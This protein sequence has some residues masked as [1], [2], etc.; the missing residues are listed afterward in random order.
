[1]SF[2]RLRLI[3]TFL[4]FLT[5]ALIGFILKDRLFPHKAQE[6]QPRYQP[7]YAAAGSAGHEEVLAEPVDAEPEPETPSARPAEPKPAA[8]ERR[9]PEA[10]VIETS[11]L[12]EE[13]PPQAPEEAAVPEKQKP[14]PPPERG[15][16]KGAQDDFFASPEDYAGKD[17][18]VELQMIT[19]RRT[20][21]GWRLN[22]V[23]SGPDKKIDYLYADD[24]DVLGEKPDLRI[25][26]VYRVRFH[27][28]KGET[29]SGNTLLLLT[30]TG[31][32]AVWA[33][34]L[35]AIE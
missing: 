28:A 5:G 18:E 17:L 7:E 4:F 16:V 13:T 23:Y 35:S 27:C 1:M 12:P 31:D 15:I 6:T 29:A 8:A 24:T 11:V 3:N 25:G 14:A 10:V 2:F 30:P 34:G 32:K 33:T 9:R 21:R 19:A 20:Q 26:Y 22:F